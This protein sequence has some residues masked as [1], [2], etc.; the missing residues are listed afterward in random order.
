MQRYNTVSIILH[1][2]IGL[3]FIG[4]VISGYVMT[5]DFIDSSIR[6]P[7]Y[8]WHKSTGLLLIFAVFARVIW[9]F[10]HKP[11][12]LPDVFKSWELKAVKAGHLALYMWMCVLPLSG[13][14]LI[15]T[16]TSGRKTEFFGLFEWPKIPFVPQSDVLND[17]VGEV[18]EILGFSLA[19]LIL[20]HVA[21]TLKHVI[22]DKQNILA[23]MWFSKSGE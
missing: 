17:I 11:P 20:V 2:V 12:A 5:R 21:A 15:T 10:A 3:A 18:H 9:R 4:M 6:Y 13:W 14:M 19:A 1:W 22:F 7:I 16:S 8:P 23:R